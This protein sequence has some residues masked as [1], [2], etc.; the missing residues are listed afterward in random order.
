MDGDRRD[1]LVSFGRDLD[2]PTQRPIDGVGIRE[3]AP[4]VGIELNE[5]LSREREVAILAAHDV[6]TAP[7]LRLIR[8]ASRTTPCR[9]R[10][11]PT[12]IWRATHDLATSITESHDLSH[13][14]AYFTIRSLPARTHEPQK[15]AYTKQRRALRR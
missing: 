8:E 10:S 3:R 14:F 1:S 6:G 15:T 13:A 7:I 2:E 12:T 11:S 5:A 4:D 9:Y